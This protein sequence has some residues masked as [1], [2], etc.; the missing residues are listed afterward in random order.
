M[1]KDEIELLLA[2][3]VNEESRLDCEVQELQNRMC[4]VAAVGIKVLKIKRVFLVVVELL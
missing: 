3:L 4:L 2:Y 1:R